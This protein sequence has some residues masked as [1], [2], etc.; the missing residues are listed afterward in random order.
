LNA[1]E[2]ALSGSHASERGGPDLFAQGS[3][4]ELAWA[5][6]ILAR[7]APE[8]LGRPPNQCTLCYGPSRLEHMTAQATSTNANHRAESGSQR[9]C[10]CLKQL[11]HDS[12]RSTFQR[13]SPSRAEDSTPRRAIR[14]PITSAQIGPVRQT[15]MAA[16]TVT[17]RGWY[18]LAGLAVPPTR[19][20]RQAA[21]A[22]SST[23]T[24]ARYPGPTWPWWLREPGRCSLM[25]L[26]LRGTG[27]FGD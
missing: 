7:L 22:T 1:S 19:F 17:D 13:C 2:T 9:T 26:L 3:I 11:S 15:P 20:G 4:V 12:D 8:A 16:H 23:S 6:D 5:T 10:S 24:L 27:E 18:L 21:K 14:G 25:R